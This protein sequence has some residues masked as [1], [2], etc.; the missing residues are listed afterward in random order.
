LF[1]PP[2][3]PLREELKTVNIN[4][5]TPLEALGFLSRLKKEA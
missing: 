1:D 2:P 4:E 3:D 5:M